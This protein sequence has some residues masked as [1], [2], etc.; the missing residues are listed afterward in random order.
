MFMDETLLIHKTRI[1]II[2]PTTKLFPCIS[3]T[4]KRHID[5]IFR[6]IQYFVLYQVRWNWPNKVLV[7]GI[8][9]NH[10]KDFVTVVWNRSQRIH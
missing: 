8:C 1:I 7:A 2:P 9:G 10:T 6:L 3:A 4:S 5:A